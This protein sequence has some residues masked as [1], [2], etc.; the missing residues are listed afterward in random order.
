MAKD[1]HLTRQLAGAQEAYVAEARR[2]LPFYVDMAKWFGSYAKIAVSQVPITT[3]HTY[4]GTTDRVYREARV[5]A[6]FGNLAL[7][8]GWSV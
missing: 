4:N 7:D 1:Q 6:H 8:G 2:H 5:A 3:Q